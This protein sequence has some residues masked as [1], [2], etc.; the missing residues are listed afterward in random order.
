[1][2]DPLRI[3]LVAHGELGGSGVVAI[4]LA[5]AL[6]ARGH[7]VH[8]IAPRRPFR[9]SEGSRVEVH[10]LPDLDHA[11]WDAPPWSLALASRI[12]DV[13]RTAD[14]DV[15]HAHFAVPYAIATEQACRV[16]GADAPPWIATL[17]GSDV[18]PLGCDPAY[19]PLVR[20]ALAQADAVTTPS[21][22]LRDLAERHLVSR[23]IEV[24]P[25]FVDGERFRPGPSRRPPS[26]TE[27]VLVHAS[28]FRS[29][30]RVGDVVKVFARVASSTSARLMLLG[31]G[32]ERDAALQELMRL[33]LRARVDA[34]GAQQR[35]E[36]WLR[37]AHVALLPSERESF[38]LAALEALAAGI[39]VVGTEVGGLPEVVVSDTMGYLGAVGDVDAM[40][41]VTLEILRDDDRWRAMAE[42]ARAHAVGQFSPEAAVGA[43]E[44]LYRRCVD[45]PL[46]RLLVSVPRSAPP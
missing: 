46:E 41:E 38:G 3:G 19:A 27:P 44:A 1:M 13:A 34:P 36:Q 11:M 26:M 28:S 40:A 32:P 35:V 42:A 15:L 12:V 31:D 17:H 16:L 22:H 18:V 9:L 20:H 21:A 29:V 24:V 5:V 37:R 33:G 8:V 39:P 2:T 4:D 43:Y 14:L 45:A 6:A 30:K 7:E 10:E 23:A 25:N